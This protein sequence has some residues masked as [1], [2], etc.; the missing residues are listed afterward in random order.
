MLNLAVILENSARTFPGKA[1]FVYPDE[2]MGEAVKAVVV[3][4]EEITVTENELM[5]WTK[6]RI[7][8]YKC[9]R[10]VEFVEA[11]PMSATGKILK[12]ELRS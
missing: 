1:T 11:L 12:K 2:K 10:H 4:K 6:E 9:P 3:L 5:A 7:A 8:T